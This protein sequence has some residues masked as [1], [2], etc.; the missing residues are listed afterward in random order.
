[1][2]ACLSQSGGRVPRPLGSGLLTGY[3][4]PKG[5]G[6][7]GEREAISAP[8]D[9]L[10]PWSRFRLRRTT[11]IEDRQK[12][13]LGQN[14]RACIEVLGPH[15]ASAVVPP[16]LPQPEAP[17]CSKIGRLIKYWSPEERS[18]RCHS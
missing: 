17:A 3:Q 5:N 7:L 18:V 8:S 9:T 12:Q 2:A 16:I 10:E 13:S 1:M 6:F 11:D 15:P 4:P 14:Q